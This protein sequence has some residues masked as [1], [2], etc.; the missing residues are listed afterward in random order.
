M[1][2]AVVIASAGI[3]LLIL[4]ITL[5]LLALKKKREQEGLNKSDSK[6]EIPQNPFYK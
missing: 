6:G 5:I 3:A 4:A 2:R 1:L